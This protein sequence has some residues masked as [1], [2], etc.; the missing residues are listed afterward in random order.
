MSLFLHTALIDVLLYCSKLCTEDF[1]HGLKNIRVHNSS[2]NTH[3]CMC[4]VYVLL[5]YGVPA[6]IRVDESCLFLFLFAV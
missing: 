4:Y 1:F 5:L 3:E 2:N 6:T